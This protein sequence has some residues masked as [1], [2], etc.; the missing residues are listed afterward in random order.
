M[1]INCFEESKITNKKLPE[2][3]KSLDALEDLEIFL[4][5]NWEN[6]SIFFTD[7]EIKSQ[8]QYLGFLSHKSIRTN[9]YIGT[10]VYKGEQ[11]NI[12]PK[13]FETDD[14]DCVLD[15]KH[16]M[17]NLAIWIEYCNKVEYPF[18]NISSELD[19]SHDLKELFISLYIGYVRSALE[20][21]LYYQYIDKKEDIHSIRGKFDVKDYLVNKIPYGQANYFNCTYSTFEFN[22]KVNKIIKYTC[23][24]L[25][26]MTSQKN[27][28]ILR[29]ILIRLSEVDDEKCSPSDCDSIRLNALNNY[30]RIIVSMSKMFMLNQL[31]NYTMDINESFCFLF[32]TELLFEGFIG[33]F[34]QEVVCDHGG[35]VYLQKSDMK[36]VDTIEYAGR[37]YAGA[38]TMRLDILVEIKEKIFILDTKYKK[39]SR[40]E[41]YPEEITRIVHEETNVGDV[42]QVCEYARKRGVSEVYLLYPMYR[43]EEKET[44]FP[45]GKSLGPKGDINIHFI[46]VPFIFENNE[47]K[48]RKQLK[49]TIESILDINE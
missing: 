47:E 2:S 49:D 16:L 28:N 26:N 34:L 43:Y 35:K 10:I 27:Q 9:N 12:F 4:Q 25:M 42:Y 3:W 39:Y 29:N 21:G 20:R 38:F 36:L 45:V 5:Q 15:T 14:E 48:V 30:Y 7:K 46:R 44:K 11:L 40:F 22:N 18:I 1:I 41:D 37:S 6:R 23:K 19:D 13:M 24:Q 32:P 31:S 8:Q 17:K 33:G